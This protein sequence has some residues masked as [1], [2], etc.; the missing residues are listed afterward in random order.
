MLLGRTTYE[1][2]SAAWSVRDGDFAEKM[3]AMPK[4]VVTAQASPL[5]W[6]SSRLAGLDFGVARA[7]LAGGRAR[8]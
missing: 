6:N 2:F 7:D 3:N 4:D 5:G 1:G 8:R